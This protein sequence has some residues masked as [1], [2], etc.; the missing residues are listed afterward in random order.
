MIMI[1][2]DFCICVCNELDARL[3]FAMALKGNRIDQLVYNKLLFRVYDQTCLLEMFVG[4]AVTLIF[5][6]SHHL[7]NPY[8]HLVQ[9][10]GK[11]CLKYSRFP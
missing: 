10:V 3:N 9:Y 2:T 4:N 7:P 1:V 8:I 5:S 11:E 6:L